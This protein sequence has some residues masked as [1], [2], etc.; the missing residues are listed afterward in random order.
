MQSPRAPGAGITGTATKS[1][2]GDVLYPN[3]IGPQTQ[4]RYRLALC[5]D[6]AADALLFEGRHTIAERLAN[7]AA[8]LRLGG[9]MM[10][11]DPGGL[12]ILTTKRPL[13]ATKIFTWHPTGVWLKKSYGNARE[14][15]FGEVWE[16]A[17]I[18][19]LAEAIQQIAANPRNMVIRGALSAAARA[20]IDANPTALVNRRKH[21]RGGIEPDFIEVP[22]RWLM[23][24][25]DNFQLRACDDL[26]DDPEGAVAYAITELLPAC[27]QDVR[28][29]WQ[30][31][32]SAGFEPGVLKVHLFYWITEPL[33]DA[34]LKRTLQQHA[35]RIVDLSVY[36]GVQPHYVASPIIEGG[37]DP[38]PRRFGWVEGLEDAVALP[39]LRPDEPRR[40]VA[41][42]TDVGGSAFGLG[43]DPLACLGDGDGLAGFHLPL[44]T[45]ALA[46]AGKVR[47][48]ACR[49]DAAFIAA[50]QRAIDAAPCRS[51]RNVSD[52]R[53]GNYLVRSIAGAFEWLAGRDPHTSRNEPDQRRK[54]IARATFRLMR[55]GIPSDELLAV[56]HRLNEQRDDPL[57]R[58]DID[59]TAVWAARR[60]KEQTNA[61]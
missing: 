40:A 30:L 39:V 37:P 21:T 44:R 35:P 43:N 26:I 14:F 47:D 11:S 49:D 9:A 7:R 15:Y 36:Q 8:E 57:P 50:C 56:L 23:V 6:R 31:S 27:F 34:V 24:D 22:R 33:I 46:Y 5:L 20:R 51:D 38:I 28:C 12:T 60:L 48:G 16:M 19:D 59:A 1:L 25:V 17:G 54:E 10:T 29:F 18:D 13:I 32:A 61:R 3:D 52:Y 55:R 42:G 58:D 53:D 45:A 41:G 4:R 2:G